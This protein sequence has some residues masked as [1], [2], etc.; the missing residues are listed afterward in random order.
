MTVKARTAVVISEL[1]PSKGI[2]AKRSATITSVAGFGAVGKGEC[3]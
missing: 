1:P 2:A 3:Y